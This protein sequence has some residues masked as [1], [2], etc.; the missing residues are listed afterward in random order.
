M[1]KWIVK[2]G[3]GKIF[4]PFSTDQVLAQIDRGYF[5]GGE[6]VAAYPGGRWVA[7]SKAPEFYDRLLDVL[8]AEMKRVD[9]QPAVDPD[10]TQ[11]AEVDG[12]EFGETTDPLTTPAGQLTPPELVSERTSTRQRNELSLQPPQTTGTFLPQG[13]TIELTDLKKIE[14]DDGGRSSKLPFIF[15]AL[16]IALVVGVLLMPD[17]KP[18]GDGKRIHLLVPRRNQPAIDVATA[19]EKFTR[20]LTSFA[21]DTFSGYQ[22][23]EY[24]LVEIV[25]GMPNRPEFTN[26]RAEWLS[27]LC[28][29]Y[30]ELWPYSYQDSADLKAVT[31]VMQEAKRAD[32]GGRYGSTCEIVQLLVNGRTRDA[33]GLTESLLVEDGQSPPLFEIRGDIFASLNDFE[34]A[35][36]YFSQA[37]ALWPAWQKS[38]VQEGRAKKQ[39]RNYPAAIQLFRSV[40]K[41]VPEH[42]VAAIE[43]GLLEALEFGH[44]DDGLNLLKPA[45]EGDEKVP[46]WV[47]SEGFLG[48]AVIYERKGQK[49]KALEYAQLAYAANSTNQEAKALIVR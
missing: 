16:A 6:Q 48:M 9:T 11:K 32:P 4:G 47:Q 34:N 12:Q 36:T 49:K 37:R 23:A 28:L 17:G 2:D 40:L 41:A 13:P 30:R 24:E 38:A 1:K 29:T 19:K 45:L 42:A 35:M 39:R 43:L 5:V 25:E 8:A 26:A 10:I 21:R 46:S 27:A 3:E 18:E 22:R 7:I 15:I 33:Q 44:L 20:A 31:W 14:K